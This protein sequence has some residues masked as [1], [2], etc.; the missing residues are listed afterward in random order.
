M[1]GT[2]LFISYVINEYLKGNIIPILKQYAPNSSI[3]STYSSDITIIEQINY[4]DP[5][6][7]FNISTDIDAEN[8]LIGTNTRF[9]EEESTTSAII[10]PDNTNIF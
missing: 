2:F 8:N 9:W 3:L 4:I 1:K 7:Y 5:V 10:A 6:N